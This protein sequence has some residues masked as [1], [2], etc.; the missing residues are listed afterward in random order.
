MYKFNIRAH[1][2]YDLIYKVF[3]LSLVR[4]LMTSEQIDNLFIA[5]IWMEK[6]YDPNNI[7]I[8]S[9]RKEFYNRNFGISIK[10]TKTEVKYVGAVDMICNIFPVAIVA[11]NPPPI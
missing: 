11:S 9:V 5:S 10:R 2:F 8:F 1:S 3:A 6:Y 4:T 7:P